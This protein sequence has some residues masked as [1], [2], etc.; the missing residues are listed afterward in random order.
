MDPCA[1]LESNRLAKLRKLGILDTHAE[2]QFDEIVN[3]VANALDMPICLISFVEDTR[4]WFKAKVGLS[5][6]ETCRSVSFCQR[7]MTL[8]DVFVVEDASK[9]PNYKDN[10]LVTGPP[11]IR[12]Y[13]GA[14]LI[15]SRGVRLGA[16]CVIS[17]EPDTIGE[18]EKQ[19]LRFG[20]SMV[21]RLVEAR[22]AS[23]QLSNALLEVEIA[24]QEA[25]VTA[26][27]M[28]AI[29]E[30]SP[31]AICTVNES[32]VV[33]SV[34]KCFCELYGCGPEK[35]LNQTLWESVRCNVSPEVRAALL[36]AALDG[37]VIKSIELKTY[38][39][40]GD[41]HDILKTL[42]PLPYGEG[43]S[44]EVLVLHHDISNL[45]SAQRMLEVRNTEFEEI[46]KKLNDLA[47]RDGLTG[48]RNHRAFQ[49]VLREWFKAYKQFSVVL[50]DV[51]HFKSYN[52]TYG[53]P[54]GDEVLK[55]VAATLEASVRPGDFV[56]RYGGEEF[57]LMFP[58]LGE[59]KAFEAVNRAMLALR[60][61]PWP[62]RKV[63][64]SFGLATIE[65]GCS[66][67]A[68]LLKRAD[69]ALYEAKRSGRD[70]IVSWTS[71]LRDLAA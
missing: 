45:K 16:L 36:R 18:A 32:G 54:A 22:H 33:R 47:S 51:D 43:E 53:H 12:F 11:H 40:K 24:R 67:P 37:E 35:F 71:D 30:H 15:T 44:R 1:W 42:V 31:V 41:E 48:L 46:N 8:D 3:F 7:T 39:E 68:E 55:S 19:I 69:L 56:A 52:D 4:Q 50:L 58:N 17:P 26:N 65:K 20:A 61:H 9:D 6:N 29:F 66:N 34:S 38:D 28:E 10:A 57:V 25:A 62:L 23:K 5:A 60:N 27:R 63:T 59:K 13:A 49:S 14:P 21:I 2:P 64:A 70:K